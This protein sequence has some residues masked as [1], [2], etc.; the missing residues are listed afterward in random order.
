MGLNPK[1]GNPE[2]LKKIIK[3]FN[4]DET[5]LNENR[6]N[7]F[8]ELAKRLSQGKNLK[9]ILQKDVK[10]NSW[11]LLKRLVK[12]G[13]KEYKCEH[14]GISEWNGKPISLQLHHKD[15]D[16][17]NQLLENL[18]ILCPN[19]HSQTKNFAGKSRKKRQIRR[20]IDCGKPIDRRAL[21]CRACKNKFLSSREVKQITREDLKSLIRTTPFTKIGEMYGVSDNAVRKWCRKYNLPTHSQDI[22][23]YSDE[24]WENI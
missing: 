21:R 13:L 1:G 15:G 10:F 9:D 8:R 11:F 17:S 12:E 3:E 19:C 23:A 6:S 14:C 16:H 4:L 18:E 7:L 20:C 24:E 2:T 5:K 22:K